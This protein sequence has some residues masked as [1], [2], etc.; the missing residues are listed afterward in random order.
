M[1]KLLLIPVLILGFSSKAQESDALAWTGAGLKFDI[2]KDL[3]VDYEFQT[4]FYKNMSTLVNFY[5]ELSVKYDIVKG[6]N[7]GVSYRYARKNRESHFAGENRLCLNLRYGYRLDMGPKFSTR[8]RY[9]HAFDRLQTINNSIIP[10][11]AQLFRWKGKVSYRND[12]FKRVQPYATGEWFANITPSPYGPTSAYRLGVGI[13]LDLPARS[14]LM[15]GYM[16]EKEFRS[17]EQNNHIYVI[18][19]TYYIPYRIFDSKG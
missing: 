15:I 1:R 12:D 11:V 14:E 3:R 17:T 5:N 8:I 2:T 18:H 19:Y 9:Q 4:R 16:Y 13:D 7:L 6:L 10:D